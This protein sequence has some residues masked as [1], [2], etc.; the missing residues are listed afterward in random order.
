MCYKITTTA[1]SSGPQSWLAPIR[2]AVI[3]IVLTFSSTLPYNEVKA[4]EI[5]NNGADD[6]GDGLVDIN[7][8]A[9]C[10]C[11][12]GSVSTSLIPNPSFEENVCIPSTPSVLGC[13][14]GWE[15]ATAG[16]A[17]YFLNV[18]DGF[19]DPAIP[20]PVPDGDGV[21][22]FAVFKS[23]QPNAFGGQ[24]TI[25]YLEFLGSCL[26]S[27]MLAGVQYTLQMDLVGSSWDGGNSNGAY[28][29]P[30]DITLYGSSA[31]PDWPLVY[32]DNIPQT[33]CPIGLDSWTELGQVTYTADET[34][35]TVTIEFT[36]DSDIQ[37]IMIG[38]PCDVPDDFLVDF[39]VISPFPY[40]WV[41][42]LVLNTSASFNAA[43]TATGGLCANDL[44]LTADFESDEGVTFQWYAEGVALI[45]QTSDT[46]EVSELNLPAGLYAVVAENQD[47]I[48]T[49]AEFE[50]EEPELVQPSVSLNPASGCAP[51]TVDFFI[52]T[53][54]STL[55]S[56][57]WE[58][59][60]NDGSSD[61]PN[62]TFTY[63]EPGFYDVTLTVVSAEGCSVT[64]V[65]T[66]LISV[67]EIPEVTFTIEPG[68]V[69]P[70]A[71]VQFIGG[72]AALGNCSWDFGDGEESAE[73][74]SA[75][76][77][78][79]EAGVYTVTLSIDL[80]ENCP[81]FVSESATITVLEVPEAA[82]TFGPQPADAFNPE[83]TFSDASG[84][85]PVS[86]EWQF[87]QE[88]ILG[89]STTQNT[90]FSF[91]GLA[92]FY[93][94]QLTVSNEAGCTDSTTALVEIVE[95]FSIYIPNAFTPDG[96]GVN[97]VLQVQSTGLDES[98]FEIDVFDRWGGKV[99]SSE[100]PH[101]AWIGNR[102]GGEYFL[103]DGIYVYRVKARPLNS[104]ESVLY[105]GSILLMR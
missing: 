40:F 12:Q 93:P 82:F 57:S 32:N 41:D 91:P 86:W 24:D 47:G 7:D 53:D 3:L 42:N 83:V 37:A 46:L 50:I 65:Y 70:G 79:E 103:P 6:D 74:P 39:F 34:W 8:G 11:I 55:A 54:P 15:Q 100:D 25:P 30:L 96:D 99:F 68:E 101:E 23:V 85:E 1:G 67:S 14:T 104:L 13:A 75:S 105:E 77:I 88:G 66:S 4:Q 43:I 84:G 81:D 69:C 28:Y 97:D 51:L 48:C 56:Q 21:A 20:L 73:C 95:F 26:L 27:P 35:Q 49:L 60:F 78:Y 45:G 61:A 17:D 2:A 59:G 44:R 58:F 19:W 36:P 52:E 31:C 80:P 62:P 18:V 90:A 87:G 89:S 76:H 33:S 10:L 29:G 71:P 22:G 64:A 102:Q 38:G 98:A 94:V 72:D 16:T 9:D 63:T 92:G 5:C